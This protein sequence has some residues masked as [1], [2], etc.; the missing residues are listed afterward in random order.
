MAEDGSG[1]AGNF[2]FEAGEADA[3][4]DNSAEDGEDDDEDNTHRR[5]RSDDAHVMLL[6]S[7]KNRV[8]FMTPQPEAVIRAVLLRIRAVC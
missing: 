7:K 8:N 6:A 5:G 3:E 1:Y 2:F 4:N